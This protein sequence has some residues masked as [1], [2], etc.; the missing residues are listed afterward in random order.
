MKINENS[1][2]QSVPKLLLLKGK[3]FIEDYC[4]QILRLRDYG[5]ANFL[6]IVTQVLIATYAPGPIYNEFGYIE[7]L[8]A[9]SFFIFLLVFIS[10]V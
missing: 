5:R 6:H 3:I 8:P 4:K 9:M 1:R 10:C 2:V 7:H